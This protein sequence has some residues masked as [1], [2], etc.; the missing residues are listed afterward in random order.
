MREQVSIRTEHYLAIVG[1]FVFLRVKV[2]LVADFGWYV[3]LGAHFLLGE[4]HWVVYDLDSYE[5]SLR[6]V[7]RLVLG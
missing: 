7:H 1:K 2:S 4:M 5:S 6:Q 3:S